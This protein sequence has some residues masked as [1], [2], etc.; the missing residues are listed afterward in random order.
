MSD[1]QPDREKEGDAPAGP[2]NPWVGWIAWVVLAPVLYVLS[3]G[4]VYWLA[5]KGYLPQEVLSIY[6][7]LECLSG[8]LESQFK[9]YIRWWIL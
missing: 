4:P 6:A 5:F 2:R 8:D 7:P 1:A 3:V 9:A